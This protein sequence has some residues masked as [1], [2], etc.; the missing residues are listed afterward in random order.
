M[1]RPRVAWR[2]FHINFVQARHGLDEIVL[3]THLFRPVRFLKYL[4]P[5]YWLRPERGDHGARI[6]RALEDLGP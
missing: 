1:I 3:A 6:R 4:S 5:F 2:L